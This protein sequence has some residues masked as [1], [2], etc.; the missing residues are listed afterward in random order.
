MPE[1]YQSVNG[2]WPDGTREGRD[3][4]PTSQEALAGAKRLYRVA[5]GKS[6][7]GPTKLVTG[8]KRT[9]I[10][11][12]VLLVNPDEGGGLLKSVKLMGGKPYVR[13]GGGWHEIVH[14]ISH[15][16]ARRLYGE[17]HG[18]RHAWIERQLIN[19][20]VSNGWLEG[21]L[22]RPE[23]VAEPGDDVRAK[24]VSIDARVKRWHSKAKRAT[25][26]PGGAL[27]GRQISP[28]W[29]KV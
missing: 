13:N 21:K 27:S 28:P 23:K 2:A 19:H 14:S 22:K 6:W 9:W 4:K 17:A 12:G 29:V 26:P 25:A 8:R 15:L 11:Y 3:L 1:K 7:R 18:P 10:R 24:L 16:A 20:V 5:M